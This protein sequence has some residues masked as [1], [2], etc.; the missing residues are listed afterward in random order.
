MT[1]IEG[2]VYLDHAA[3]THLDNE[4]ARMLKA[5]LT[6]GNP[7]AAYADD[8][9]TVMGRYR[10]LVC[11]YLGVSVWSQGQPGSHLVFTSGATESNET[12]LR[13]VIDGYRHLD[14]TLTTKPH[15]VISA[16]EHSAFIE[17]ATRLAECAYCDVTRVGCDRYGFVAP[18][19]V[20]AALRPNTVLTCVLHASN[21]TGGI[22]DIEG[23]L[24]VCHAKSVPVHV[25][26][27]QT[28][29]KMSIPK[30]IDSISYSSHKFGGLS[31]AGGLILGSDIIGGY[32]LGKV[33]MIA[34][35][36][37]MGF[38]GGTE[39]V[40]GIVT[41]YMA[42]GAAL[43]SKGD[44]RKTIC[45]LRERLVSGLRSRFPCRYLSEYWEAVARGEP[46]AKQFELI[47]LMDA[48][49]RDLYMPGILLIAITKW[50]EAKPVV[51]N[52]EI[53]TKLLRM[54]FIVSVGSAC[55][56]A[57]PTASHVVASMEVPVN[58]RRGVLR[59]S[60]GHTNTDAEI[61]SFVKAFS[62]T[63]GTYA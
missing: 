33:P 23:V 27:V 3:T 54:G 50:T 63:V 12:I 31:G 53:K 6:M 22:N 29:G 60:L 52:T 45:R 17:A 11:K 47:L 19:S 38:R 5:S 35:S 8:I 41:G 39:N 42:L 48:A 58:M 30:D 55:S 18:A 57:S 25:D 59:I 34:G 15:I 9:K 14:S 36:Q 28:F 24:R 43:G 49:R 10:A 4:A 1:G 56:T 62:E 46:P 16:V 44:R 2:K 40:P 7:S 37:N 26:C 32:E 13:M 20:E 21:E 61:D 51:C